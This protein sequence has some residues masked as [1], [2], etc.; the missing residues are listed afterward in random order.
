MEINTQKA[1]TLNY[2]RMIESRGKNEPVLER[3]FEARMNRVLDL[4]LTE[5]LGLLSIKAAQE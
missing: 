5:N 4:Y 3:L 1:V 2:N